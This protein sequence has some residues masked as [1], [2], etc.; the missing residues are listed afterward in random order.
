MRQRVSLSA[1]LDS[2]S[3]TRFTGRVERDHPKKASSNGALSKA[4]RRNTAKQI[5]QQKRHALVTSIRSLDAPRVVVCL[6]L[7]ED[8]DP[9]QTALA[10]FGTD[11]E[12]RGGRT[13][14]PISCV[15]LAAYS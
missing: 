6:S 2:S 4:A 9:E 14:W 3:R 13:V 8:I 5:Q 10:L 11:A 1:G 15:H 12:P 7:T